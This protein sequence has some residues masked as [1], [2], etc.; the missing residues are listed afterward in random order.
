MCR[1]PQKNQKRELWSNF[2]HW[3]LVYSAKPSISIQRPNQ[4]KAV[5][6][7]LF[8]EVF[9][10]WAGFAVCIRCS[11]HL[12]GKKEK[13][14][15]RGFGSLLEPLSGFTVEHLVFYFLLISAC[16]SFWLKVT[17]RVGSV[18]K[19]ECWNFT[20]FKILVEYSE[21]IINSIS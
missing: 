15:K 11:S 7:L 5:A 8:W 4:P 3:L 17:C 10:I 13:W 12:I 20:E 16:C 21:A 1:L 19:L 6:F 18:V 2:M 9:N 14:M